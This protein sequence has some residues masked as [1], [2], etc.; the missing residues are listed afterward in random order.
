MKRKPIF[1]GNNWGAKIKLSNIGTRIYEQST[2]DLNSYRLYTRIYHLGIIAFK[3]VFEG[4][5]TDKDPIPI[6]V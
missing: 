1:L 5:N 3:C 4:Q 6:C 2:F